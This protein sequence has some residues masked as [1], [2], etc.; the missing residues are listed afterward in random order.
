MKFLGRSVSVRR[1]APRR[2]MRTAVHLRESTEREK[3]CERLPILE[4]EAV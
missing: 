3:E 1:C 2:L 4:L